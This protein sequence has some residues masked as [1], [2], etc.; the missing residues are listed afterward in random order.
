MAERTLAQEI[1]DLMVLWHNLDRA[2]E[3]AVADRARLA[4]AGK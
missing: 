4:P 1:I 3:I 2:T